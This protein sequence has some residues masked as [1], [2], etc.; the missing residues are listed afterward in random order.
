MARRGSSLSLTTAKPGTPPANE[1]VP[2]RAQ[3]LL[4]RAKVAAHR[5]RR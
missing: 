4:F 1:T 5:A 3:A 2:T